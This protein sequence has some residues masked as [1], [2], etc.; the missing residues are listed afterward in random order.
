LVDKLDLYA[1]GLDS[2]NAN[3]DRSKYASAY[4]EGKKHLKRSVESLYEVTEYSKEHFDVTAALSLRINASGFKN[5]VLAL[6]I[7]VSG[8]FHPK[9]NL[10]REEAD[11][12][13]GAEAKLV[14]WPYLRQI[15]SDTTARMH[16]GTITLP[17]IVS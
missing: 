4:A 13:A 3:L 8:H 2:L 6:D 12:F 17:L 1:I 5:P 16:I 14:F 10:S 15:V 7:R 11:E 9:K